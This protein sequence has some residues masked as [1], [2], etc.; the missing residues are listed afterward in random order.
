MNWAALSPAAKAVYPV[1]ASFANRQGIAFPGEQK[2]AD[3]AGRT[4][5]K[6]R[7]GIRDLE[8]FPGFR[9]APYVTKRGRRSKKFFL[10]LPTRSDNGQAFPVYKLTFEMGYWLK[11]LP[12]A[13]ALYPVIRRFS[14]FEL[15]LYNELED[16][17]GPDV[18]DF[19]REDYSTRKYDFCNADRGIMAERAGITIRSMRGALESLQKGLL[20]EPV[21]GD[22][23]K[24]YFRLPPTRWTPGH[25][26]QRVMKAHAHGKNYR[27]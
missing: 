14:Y 24:V 22:T 1:I 2:I 17:E 13:Q 19:F 7:E 20:I 15:D 12:S 8:G 26:N 18:A 10:E 5:K 27:S 3:L 25:L 23:W 11:L 4:E 9:V 16:Q 21:D 6:A